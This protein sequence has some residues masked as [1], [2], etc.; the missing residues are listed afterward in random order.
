MS[1]RA[2]VFEFRV[3]LDETGDVMS[4]RG[5]V[6]LPA[7]DQEAWTPEHLL[8]AGLVRCVLK[9]LRFHADRAG[10]AV[11]H[12]ATAHGVVTKRE[13]DGRYALSAAELDLDV[14]LVP[15]PRE[16][17]LEALLGKA[18]RDCWVGASLTVHPAYHW[19]VN[20]REIG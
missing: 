3:L 10:I 13:S 12:R 8:L 18:E 15:E 6:A 7:D 1:V 4:E 14:R 2:R 20:E 16:G 11:T 5:G 9:S 17:E 19:V